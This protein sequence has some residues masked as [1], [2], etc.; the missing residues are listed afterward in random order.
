MV[1]FPEPGFDT[2]MGCEAELVPTVWEA[3]VSDVG[4]SDMPAVGVT[5][6]PVRGTVWGD[7]GA[8]SVI[9]TEADR[10]PL[11]V[12]VNW[13]DTM[14]LPPPARVGQLFA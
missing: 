9:C 14:Q 5:P 4:L 3:N 10:E 12:G 7:P 13:I 6:V 11:A 1:R 2:V 8:L